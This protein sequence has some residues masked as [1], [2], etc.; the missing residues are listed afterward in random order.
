[1]RVLSVVDAT[2]ASQPLRPALLR[3]RM[4]GAT[5]VVVRGIL[6]MRHSAQRRHCRRGYAQQHRVHELGS[7]DCV[8]GR[9]LVFNGVQQLFEATTRV[10]AREFQNL[11]N[12]LY[13]RLIHWVA[14]P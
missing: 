3:G 9:S 2:P 8:H 4:R 6:F 13:Y 10:D 1:M 14:Y 7:V 12:V 11:S 5:C